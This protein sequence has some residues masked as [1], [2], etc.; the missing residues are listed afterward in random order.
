M[1]TLAR[2]PPPPPPYLLDPILP[3]NRDDEEELLRVAES[4]RVHADHFAWTVPGLAITAEAFLLTIALANTT[5]PVGRLVAVV[6]G[7]FGVIGALHVICKQSHNFDIYDALIEHQRLRLGRMSMYRET[8]EGLNLPSYTNL[9][10]RGERSRF[11]RHGAVRMWKNVLFALLLVNLAIF[12]YAI[13]EWSSADP[14]WL[15]PS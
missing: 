12:V 4:R 2:T 6:A 7:S 13:L 9:M 5:A 3:E 1:H 15:N 10:R 11:T 14:G 8:I